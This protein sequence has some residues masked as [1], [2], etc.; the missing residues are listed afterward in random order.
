[1]R[2]PKGVIRSSQLKNDRQ[3]MVNKKLHR[4]RR[5]RDPIILMTTYYVMGVNSLVG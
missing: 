5:L 2:I 3:T 1:M 4:T